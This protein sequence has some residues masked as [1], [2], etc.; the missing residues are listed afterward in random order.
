MRQIVCIFCFFHNSLPS[1]TINFFSLIF[2]ANELLRK[3]NWN[4][5]LK[6]LL[7]GEKFEESRSNIRQILMKVDTLLDDTMKG[8][9]F[10][11]HKYHIYM[12][13]KRQCQAYQHL[14]IEGITTDKGER[15]MKEFEHW[16]ALV[17]EQVDGMLNELLD[18]VFE[19]GNLILFITQ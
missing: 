13:Y 8:Y 6:E 11:Q 9:N 2:I 10:F 7:P 17:N 14:V 4:S 1:F 18:P 5:R 16:K 15:H 3:G 12:Y 19:K